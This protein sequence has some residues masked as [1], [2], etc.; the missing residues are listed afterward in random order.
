MEHSRN[1][2]KSISAHR[3]AKGSTVAG[4]NHLSYGIVYAHENFR[5]RTKEWEWRDSAGYSLPTKPDGVHLVYNLSSR[6][7][8]TTNRFA[9]FAEDA[10]YFESS[11]AFI[12]LNAGLRMSYWDFN[13]EFLCIAA[14][15][16]K[17]QSG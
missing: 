10:I 9:V 8:I 15:E 12:T 17:F 5:D 11:K 16:C 4:R 6:Q 3:S 14:R 1:R 7:D 13:K 2:L